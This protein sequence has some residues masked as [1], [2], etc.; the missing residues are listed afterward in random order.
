[1]AE[2]HIGI[3][4]E[5]RPHID[6]NGTMDQTSPPVVEKSLDVA[7]DVPAGYHVNTSKEES[8]LT[9]T[10]ETTEYPDSKTS[11]VI[12]QEELDAMSTEEKVK[13]LKDYSDVIDIAAKQST[14]NRE[15]QEAWNQRD[16]MA[17]Y[18]KAEDGIDPVAIITKNMADIPNSEVLLR[19]YLPYKEKV[20]E[21]LTDKE[22]GVVIDMD[23]PE[24]TDPA[25]KYEF[26]KD[27][28]L[29]FKRIDDSIAEYD[30]ISREA[31]EE[32]KKLNVEI[33]EISRV[34]SSNVLTYIESL[35]DTIKPDDPGY[36]VAQKTI[37]GVESA[38]N[39]K[40]IFDTLEKYE[41]IVRN[42]VDDFK[43]ESRITDIGKRYA[44]NLAKTKTSVNL[45]T[46]LPRSKNTK[47]IEAA[48]VP[49][50]YRAGTEDLLVFIFIRYFSNNGNL[51]TV[52]G[53]KFHAALYHML[54]QLMNN[55]L[56][57]ENRDYVIEY[58]KKLLQ[59]HY[60]KMPI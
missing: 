49:K 7:A 59:L 4:G 58:I 32:M 18:M 14:M 60:D 15:M 23:V 56:S 16:Q 33:K 13:V 9:E 1:M 40:M 6:I 2:T 34:M 29:F 57:D 41:S 43:R 37:M 42:T 19:E 30:R 45:I 21:L 53:K 10:S 51:D 47:S 28:L 52:E 20:Q 35:K 11:S 55:Q 39:F 12:T 31:D 46:F 17:Q 8:D 54:Y 50:F 44:N 24:D 36:D 38:Y 27:F 5:G 26:T 48:I 3:S 22:T 25:K